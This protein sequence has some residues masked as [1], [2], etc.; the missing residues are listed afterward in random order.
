MRS[1]RRVSTKLV[2]EKILTVFL[3][4]GVGHAGRGVITQRSRGTPSF[5]TSWTLEQ[6][7]GHL[8]T[9][10]KV[11]NGKQKSLFF[12]THRAQMSVMPSGKRRTSGVQR[13]G[14]ERS[15]LWQLYSGTQGSVAAKLGLAGKLARGRGAQS[16]AY[17]LADVE[18]AWLDWGRLSRC[19]FPPSL[20][21]RQSSAPR[22]SR[23]AGAVPGRMRL[24]VSVWRRIGVAEIWSEST[25]RAQRYR[26]GPQGIGGTLSW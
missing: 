4:H 23:R 17:M 22:I 10:Q 19:W 5:T 20:L 8:W 16:W 13:E 18:D 26:R 12:N 25:E 9:V 15:R 14:R 6:E 11:A 3:L 21:Y 7:V 2:K 1:R 24:R